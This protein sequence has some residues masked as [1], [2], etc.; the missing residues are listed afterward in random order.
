MARYEELE[1]RRVMVTGAASGIGL[2]T[3]C[4]FAEEG[5]RVFVVDYNAEALEETRKAHPEFAGFSPSSIIF[6]RKSV[7]T[8]SIGSENAEAR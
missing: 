8:A 7:C 6:F 2:A 5:A 3:A 1:G 4:R